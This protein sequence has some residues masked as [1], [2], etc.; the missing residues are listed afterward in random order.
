MEDLRSRTASQHLLRYLRWQKSG[1]TVRKGID[2]ENN[3]AKKDEKFVSTRRIFDAEAFAA[4]TDPSLSITII[5]LRSTK[6]VWS[7]WNT[8]LLKWQGWKRIHRQKQ[9]N[10][11]LLQPNRS[12]ALNF[13]SASTSSSKKFAVKVYTDCTIGC[14]DKKISE[15]P[16]YPNLCP[17]L[18]KC[19][20]FFQKVCCRSYRQHKVHCASPDLQSSRACSWVAVVSQAHDVLCSCQTVDGLVNTS[21][22]P[23]Q[24]RGPVPVIVSLWC[25]K[26]E[27]YLPHPH[28]FYHIFHSSHERAPQSPLL[29]VW[30]C[31]WAHFCVIM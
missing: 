7:L 17:Q 9:E 15:R 14:Q 31:F 10:Y 20:H 24:R 30:V 21:G 1:E 23:R 13:W 18:L 3:Y 2:H 28:H 4:C 25:I 19:F 5:S 26:N 6:S 12:Y 22:C 11:R 27:V 16:T 29:S 8:R